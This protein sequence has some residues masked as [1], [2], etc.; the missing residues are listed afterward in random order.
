MKRNLFLLPVMALM[1]C[2]V[3]CG[4]DDD[5]TVNPIPSGVKKLISMTETSTGDDGYEVCRF[6]YDKN[7]NLIYAEEECYEAGFYYSDV[8]TYEW[9]K[10]GVTMSCDGEPEAYYRIVDGKIVDGEG[11]DDDKSYS[12]SYDNSGYLK[13]YI[14]EYYDDERKKSVYTWNGGKLMRRAKS[15]DYDG[16]AYIDKFT[17]SNKECEGF[18]PLIGDYT[19]DDD[20]LFYAAPWL[21]GSVLKSLPT[22]I[23][24]GE[25]GDEATLAVSYAFYADGYIKSCVLRV[26]GGGIK[27]YEFTWE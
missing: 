14:E 1:L 10:D 19:E 8:Y 17:Y 23:E 13:M 26:E 16:D 22:R 12:F 27:T 5:E 18:F 15:Y 20:P 11:L 2:V 7:G 24:K 21:V 6:E 25:P 4:G 9:S 3:A